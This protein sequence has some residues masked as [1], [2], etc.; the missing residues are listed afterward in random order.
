MKTWFLGIFLICGL[1]NRAHAQD[2]EYMYGPYSENNPHLDEDKRDEGVYQNV[3]RFLR[4]I[5]LDPKKRYQMLVTSVQA[6]PSRSNSTL[7][8]EFELCARGR[9]R[10]CT[11]KQI[12]SYFNPTEL[13]K[14]RF[15]LGGG[16]GK[17]IDEEFADII[18]RYVPA[19]SRST[20]KDFYVGIRV[21]APS[22]FRGDEPLL[23]AR[24]DLGPFLTELKEGRFHKRLT[25]RK[26]D[27]QI[28][29]VGR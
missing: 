11:K 6:D 4:P 29:I 18:E 13:S 19:S 12:G 24:F 14:S 1:L 2:T 5:G 8:I 17:S 27:F 26:K 21:L 10:N 3:I 20:L 16:D 28:D 9:Y 23:Y 22:F 15:G 7:N 25:N